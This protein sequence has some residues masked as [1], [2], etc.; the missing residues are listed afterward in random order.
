MLGL[1]PWFSLFVVLLGAGLARLLPEY[2]WG[3]LRR[4]LDG[5]GAPLAIAVVAGALSFWLWGSLTRSPVM[6][7][8][9]AYLLQAELFA[10]LRWTGAAP[11]L[12]DFFRQLHVFVDGTLA[13]KYPPGN[14]IVLALG[15]LAGMPGLP[16]VVMSALASALLFVV[17]R[18]IAG[19]PTALLAWVVWQSSFPW[20][21]DHANYMS[22][23]VTS[24]AWLLTWWAMLRWR[25]GGGRR[26]LAGAAAAAAWCV[27]TRPLT[28]A[29]LG[30]VA[31]IVAVRLCQRRRAWRDLVPGLATGALVLATIPVWNWRTT[32]DVWTTPLSLFSR[33]FTPFDKLG[34][35]VRPELRPRHLPR[36]QWMT[37]AAF[38]QEHARHTIP[39]LPSIA[40]ERITMLDRDAW[41]EWRGSLRLF[42]LFGLLTLTAEG[43]IALAAFGLQFVAYLA[44][45]H[46]AWYTLYYL[47]CTPILAFITA[48]GIVRTFAILSVPSTA[49][50][51]NAPRR[52]LRE[53]LRLAV[54]VHSGVGARGQ[55][56][57][58]TA[59]LLVATAGSIAGIAVARQ[60]RA[61]ID[62]DHAYYDAFAGAVRQIHDPRAIVFVRYS[63]KHPDG[64]SLVRNVPDLA[65]APVWTVYDRGADNARLLALAPGRVPYLFDESKWSLSRVQ[66]GTASAATDSF[67]IAPAGSLREPPADQRRR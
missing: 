11:P 25:D 30:L 6:H 45:A 57:V 21:Y 48:L 39:A 22:E 36:D 38:Y 63:E 59:S 55:A 61:Q 66:P 51:A 50:P 29:A 56:R 19:G 33:Q 14:S 3:F 42:A 41:Y 64:L 43:W 16:V 52:S 5:R 34:F 13:S 8:E 32:G 65:S 28:G 60:V 35:G 44:F 37:S 10:R 26:W 67:R 49:T 1:S 4:Q 12:P 7:D 54:G 24:L 47:E 62:N 15:V 17:A 46:P 2:E 18:R 9:S 27:I 58:V 23:G 31:L 40:R 53:R 20:M